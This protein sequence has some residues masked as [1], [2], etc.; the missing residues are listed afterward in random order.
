MTD[1]CT[2]PPRDPFANA[3]AIGQDNVGRKATRKRHHGLVFK[4][5]GAFLHV[6]RERNPVFGREPQAH[7]FKHGQQLARQH[8]GKLGEFARVVA[9][10]VVLIIVLVE[11]HPE[12]LELVMNR[13]F[14][15]ADGG[16]G[17]FDVL[18][19]NGEGFGGSVAPVN[20]NLPDAEK[21]L[22]QQ[23]GSLAQPHQRRHGV[24]H[25]VLHQRI[26]VAQGAIVEMVMQQWRMFLKEV[27][28]E[29]AQF[30]PVAGLQHQFGKTNRGDGECGLGD[31]HGVV[32]YAK[33]FITSLAG[34]LKPVSKS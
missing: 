16:L 7:V 17:V 24:Q 22:G 6:E 25:L 14:A 21:Q 26:S 19:Q 18:A 3:D 2:K 11:G 8:A 34:S 12:R 23:R 30:M 5:C 33:T 27:A 32:G 29:P 28:K 15:Q 31:W 10:A 9:L 4:L 20:I 13:R 1:D